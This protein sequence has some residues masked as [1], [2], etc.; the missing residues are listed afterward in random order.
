LKYVSSDDCVNDQDAEDD[1]PLEEPEERMFESDGALLV[2]ETLLLCFASLV[3]HRR[4]P[5]MCEP[6][7]SDTCN[8]TKS[9]RAVF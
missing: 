5:T 1:E 2:D 6:A 7:F 8:R 9:K 3:H 4:V